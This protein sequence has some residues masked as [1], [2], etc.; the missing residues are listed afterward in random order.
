MANKSENREIIIHNISV[1]QIDMVYGRDRLPF[2]KREIR[3]EE[4]GGRGYKRIE[5]S[6]KDRE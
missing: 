5:G 1:I 6:Q 3:R 2:I 4:R